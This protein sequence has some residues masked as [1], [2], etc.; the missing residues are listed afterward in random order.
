MVLTFVQKGLE[1]GWQFG[2]VRAIG[3]GLDD[4]LR[5]DAT[6][7]STTAGG[8]PPRRCSRRAPFPLLVGRMREM[9]RLTTSAMGR[10]AGVLQQAFMSRDDERHC[11]HEPAHGGAFGGTFDPHLPTSP[12]R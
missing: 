7:G 4:T 8:S 6:A 11:L 12:R 3:D 1:L 9:G 2:I 5:R 10:L